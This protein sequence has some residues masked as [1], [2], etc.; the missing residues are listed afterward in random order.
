MNVLKSEIKLI[1]IS[2]KLSKFLHQQNI[3]SYL[4]ANTLFKFGSICSWTI[5]LISFSLKTF[6]NKALFDWIVVIY[7]PICK[8]IFLIE[9]ELC[10]SF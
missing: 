6:E 1:E 3:L 8:Q 4:F 7:Q 9:N 2:R 5:C 10:L